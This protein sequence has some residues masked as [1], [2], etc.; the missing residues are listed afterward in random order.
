[1]RQAIV[2][3]ARTWI[4]TPWQHQQSCK[5]IG[6]DC[7]GLISGVGRELGFESAKAFRSDP[8]FKGYGRT[9]DTAMIKAAIAEYLDPVDEAQAGDVLFMNHERQPIPHHFGIYAGNDYLI[10]AYAQARKVTEH[11][12]DDTWRT[13]IVAAFKFREVDG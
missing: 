7:I 4:G 13:R 9:P 8:R 6:C 3:E 5:G 2:A 10:H 12:I 11:R 1:M